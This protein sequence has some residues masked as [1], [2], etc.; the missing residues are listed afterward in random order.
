MQRHEHKKEKKRGSIRGYF[1]KRYIRKITHRRIGLRLVPV[2]VLFA[3]FKKMIIIIFL[4]FH[5]APNGSTG[6]LTSR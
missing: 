3:K 1:L 6:F 4:R 2:A 5:V